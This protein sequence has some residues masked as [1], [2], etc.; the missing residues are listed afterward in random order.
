VSGMRGEI[1]SDRM[2][3]M[4]RHPSVE[5]RRIAF[6]GWYARSPPL[7]IDAQNDAVVHRRRRVYCPGQSP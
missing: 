3:G 6:D 7:V 5:S 1:S 2:K 4:I